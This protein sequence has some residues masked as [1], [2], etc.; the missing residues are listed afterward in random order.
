MGVQEPMS[1]YLPQ[2]LRYLCAEKGPVAQVCRD[3]GINQQQFSKYLHGRSKP[4]GQ[5]LRKIA[6][7]FGVRDEDLFEQPEVLAHAYRQKSVGSGSLHDPFFAAFPGSLKDLRR[8]LGVYQT[9]NLS[10]AA[11]DSVVVAATELEERDGQV[12]SR[13][14]DSIFIRSDGKSQNSY[15]E[16]KVAYHGERIFVMEFEAQNSGSF[17]MT[18]LYPPHRYR[19]NYLFGMASF[20]ASQPQ[21]VPYASR[22][23]W[24][25]LD[26]VGLNDD[27]IKNCG[28]FSMTSNRIGPAVRNFLQEDSFGLPVTPPFD[29]PK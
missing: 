19:R 25:R 5:N 27:I 8:F 28:Q 21:R 13:T 4:A 7:Y 29:I 9:Y 23:V 18:T 20:L 16:G 22:T 17:M 6:R 15:Y 12:F 3:I 2:N 10:P 1:S 11:P 14:V 24:E 26:A